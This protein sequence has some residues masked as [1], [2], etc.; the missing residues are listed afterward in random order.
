[1]GY[2]ELQFDDPD[3][4]RRHTSRQ[5]VAL[6]KELGVGGDWR[7][8]EQQNVGTMFWHSEQPVHDITSLGEA[9]GR[10]S[11]D[12][13][14]HVIRGKLQD[15]RP[16]STVRRTVRRKKLIKG[17]DHGFV[18]V[19]QPWVNADIDGWPIPDGVGGSL[20]EL[21]EAAITTLMPPEFHDV[22]TFL[23]FSGSAG[24]KDAKLLRMHAWFWFDR[25]VDNRQLENWLKDIQTANTANGHGK[26]PDPALARTV[27]MHFCAD[28][29]IV[30]GEDPIRRR[31]GWL[32]GSRDEVAV[33]DL[34]QPDLGKAHR[35]FSASHGLSPSQ[36]HSIDVHLTRL[37][38]FEYGGGFNDV[39]ISATWAYARATPTWERDRDALKAKLRKAIR[40]APRG[41]DRTD[42]EINKY[43]SD[44]WLD[45]QITGAFTK[46]A[47][48]TGSNWQACEPDFQL[49][50]LTVDEC[51]KRM[52]F[53]EWEFVTYPMDAAGLTRQGLIAS[54]LGLGKSTEVQKLAAKVIPKRKTEGVP[55]KI[56]L[57]V[58]YHKLGGQMAKNLEA[59]GLNVVVWLGREYETEDGEHPACDNVPVVKMARK[60]GADIDKQVC[61]NSKQQCPF[62]LTCYYQQ[63]R[64]QAKHADVVICAHDLLRN[65]LPKE[66]KHNL[67][68]I[69]LEEGFL[70]E[71]KPMKLQAETLDTDITNIRN[72]P[73]LQHNA[74]VDWQAT[75][76]LVTLRKLIPREFRGYITMDVLE[77]TGLTIAQCNSGAGLERKRYR[78]PDIHPGM[79]LRDVEK[80]ARD[81]APNNQ[82]GRLAGLWDCFAE[83]LGSEDD[84]TGRTELFVDRTDNGDCLTFG[85]NR[86]NKFSDDCLE[87]PILCLDRTANVDIARHYL[88]R[89]ELL[90]T[91]TPV[92][93]HATIKQMPDSKFSLT[94]L[95]KHPEVLEE[96]IDW[97]QSKIGNETACVITHQEFEAAFHR[98]LGIITMHFGAVAGRND[99]ENV[100]HLFEIGQQNP[101]PPD[102]RRLSA[103]VTGSP[104]PEEK[105]ISRTGGILMSDGTGVELEVSRFPNPMSERMRA[106][107]AEASIV[108]A[109]GRG[110]AVNRTAD[111]PLTIW[112]LS[113]TIL[114]WPVD[115]LLR[116][117][118]EALGLRARTAARGVEFECPAHAAAFYPDLFPRRP[119]DDDPPDA[120]KYSVKGANQAYLRS[121]NEGGE[122]NN[123]D[124]PFIGNSYKGFVVV[125]RYKTAGANQKPHRVWCRHDTDLE[126]L[127]ARLATV[128]GIPLAYFNVVEETE[129]PA[130]QPQAP[131]PEISVPEILPIVVPM[132]RAIVG[133]LNGML[134]PMV[135]NAVADIYECP[136]EALCR[137][138][139]PWLYE[140]EVEDTAEELE[141]EPPDPRV[142]DREWSLAQGFPY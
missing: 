48:V 86:L 39:L 24:F 142:F 84:L 99:A 28:P 37:G 9:V 75:D 91:G 97:V 101:S 113:K 27:Q 112:S 72:Q 93:P 129:R 87:Y 33:P 4:R 92:T 61:S 71:P 107:V 29:V 120:P 60:A 82:I 67:A 51:R 95:R 132:D 116:W 114:P 74:N 110:R 1:M 96:L 53:A 134:Q 125:V 10:V 141:W 62:A 18:A 6:F 3:L 49:P 45:F 11:H 136:F 26:S 44:A 102:T 36:A 83:I 40:E 34:K 115:T 79:A 126:A 94:Y 80:I 32:T 66:I 5:N 133:I 140:P 42:S 58:P 55:H 85:I 130:V 104:V 76:E 78:K 35:G 111:N 103:C 89:I 119:K 41:P 22:T 117:E 109:V 88:P 135:V 50:T 128:L 139:W 73:C 56:L 131:A 108:Q 138:A 21:G 65:P 2:F 69:V 118:D 81:C 122:V 19:P 13:L 98:I 52:A 7:K 43:L 46:Q 105:W 77:E 16:P 121:K 25:P 38:D 31:S 137:K 23:Q 123:Y 59:L 17:M 14:S 68:L 127:E 70:G 15:D 106:Q 8:D 57:A 12:P 90:S 124:I 63:T 54:E 64:S 30:G 100:R 20:E 47:M